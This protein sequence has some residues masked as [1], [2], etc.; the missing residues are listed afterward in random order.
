MYNTHIPIYQYHPHHRKLDARAESHKNSALSYN[1]LYNHLSAILCRRA[2][3]RPPACQ[4][5]E[6]S[7]SK[8]L[9][10]EKLSP[11]IPDKYSLRLRKKNAAIETFARN[12]LPCELSG[13]TKVEIFGIDEQ[14][15]LEDITSSSGSGPETSPP[16]R[17][18]KDNEPEVVEVFAD[19]PHEFSADTPIPEDREV[20]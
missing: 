7:E 19:A 5:L 9:E 13:V 18:L 17:S 20:L 6:T 3:E 14:V 2:S 10:L 15:Q 8:M 16:R 4:L 11:L 12:D 1:E